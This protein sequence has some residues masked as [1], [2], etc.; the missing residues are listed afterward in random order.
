MA[1]YDQETENANDLNSITGI[2]SA[3][4]RDMEARA[5]AGADQDKAARN[6]DTVGK[7]YSS[8]D[9]GGRFSNLKG[10][11]NKKKAGIGLG[12]AGIGGG[13]II[14]L[15]GILQGPMQ[16]IHL[17]QM[18]SRN[19]FI[20]EDTSSI[21]VNGLFRYARSE[22]NIGETRV[23]GL[24]SWAFGKTKTQLA[25]IGIEF[26]Q[27]GFGHM[28]SATYDTSKLAKQYP[29]L[30]NM[31]EAEA[32]SSLSTRLGIPED[33]MSRIGMGSDVGG[34][35]FAVNARTYGYKSTKVLQNKSLSLLDNG[36]ITTAMKGRVVAR[37]MGIP[38][39]FHPV[40]KLTYDQKKKFAT[41]V[42][43]KKSEKERQ[44][45]IKPAE[46]SRGAAAKANIKD[47]LNSNRGVLSAALLGSA[48]MCVVR[49]VA[50]DVPAANRALIVAPSAAGAT[51]AI[52]FG[53]QVQSGD[54]FS[55]EQVGAI[56]ESYVDDNGK[57]IWSASAL[58]STAGMDGSGE[59]LSPDYKQA[60]SN[61]TTA[62]T[63]LNVLDTGGVG[64]TVCSTAGQVVQIVGGLALLAAGPFTG[65][66]S[67]GVFA[68]K[69]GTAMAATAGAIYMLQTQLS[70]L[71]DTDAVMPETLSGP[72][73]GN[74]LAY[75]A[76]ESSN[77]ASRAEGGIALSSSETAL[78]EKQ[79][80]AK[81]TEEFQSKNYFARVFDTSDYRSLASRAI[82][83]QDP[84][85]IKN[86]ASIVGNIMNIPKLSSMILS[87]FSHT[88]S[89]DTSYDWPFPRYGIPRDIV[90]DEKYEDPYANADQVAKILESNSSYIEKAKIC[91][92]A[93]V[94]KGT[95]GWD[96]VAEEDVNPNEK[97]YIDANCA[98]KNDEN[99]KRIML[100]VFD[101]RTM[102]AVA[103]FE[104]EEDV[105]QELG[106]S[107]TSSSDDG[108][109]VAPSNSA[110]PSGE[111]KDLAKQI[112]DS[113]KIT[114]DP[115][116]M[117]QIKAIA[118]GDESCH[119]NPTILSL[120]V[121]ISEKHTI[122]ITSLNRRCT[123][124]ITPS[125]EGSYHYREQGGHAVDI[126]IVDGTASTGS[127]AKDIKL[128]KE[129]LPVLPSGSGIGQSGCRSTPLTMPSGVTQFADSCDHVHI[130]VPVK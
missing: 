46:S 55:M 107:A 20:S 111:P 91:F 119:V 120:L 99:W 98:D 81:S 54:D 21:R 51:S 127:G 2:G 118:N 80:N 38:T 123:G 69:Q 125:G 112:V 87:P 36:K 67:W 74:L 77:I 88:A 12:V 23:T 85:P 92:G 19:N 65:G 34:H 8:S 93:T 68:A 10:R 26:K 96:V 102:K 33:Q 61:D 17:A 103:C 25:S 130:Q 42:D 1:V 18:L 4:E 15:F 128:L 14:G 90:L 32:R 84:D 47:K 104:G 60:F 100:F 97:D 28:K 11:I 9:R 40:K 5:A 16:S 105:C 108:S 22:G 58:K 117:A 27:D 6:D 64:S 110:L 79:E 57:S 31:T 114:G 39:L 113:P 24:G 71:L 106:P 121:L 49:D 76:R 45:K 95:D 115:R 66:G 78:L 30:K 62:E 124:V 126:G 53:S 122:Y 13:G 48:A 63:I 83:S 73:G 43:R 7:G 75:G 86:I 70:A 35:K 56:T 72:L 50:K 3:E 37:Y 116:Y 44:K 109:S 82:Q 129:I 89:A 59:D 41:R 29:E 101:T 52:S 94:S